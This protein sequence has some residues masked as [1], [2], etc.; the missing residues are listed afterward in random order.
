MSKTN[1]ECKGEEMSLL[2]FGNMKLPK[3]TA[4]FN[5]PP[6]M[7]CPGSTDFCK[8]I[9]YAA[10]ASRIYPSARAHRSEAMEA[11]KDLNNF[12]T[13]ILKELSENRKVA[14][15]RIHE[16]GDFY[17]QTYFDAW[18]EI[19]KGRPD[20]NFYAYTKTWFLNVLFKP[21]NF[22]VFYSVDD[23]TKHAAPIGVD[24]IAYTSQEK[25]PDPENKYPGFPCWNFKENKGMK[26]KDGC[27]YCSQP[28][29]QERH[30][31]FFKH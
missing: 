31:T 18:C 22:T 24:G 10:K 7:T 26:C 9:C 5:L 17:S 19:A 3:T 14:T 15:V 1:N 21:E 11:T 25:A 29:K 8:K 6:G 30:V 28:G 23:T 2:T 27:T 4:I 20:L 16:S 12:K 13:A